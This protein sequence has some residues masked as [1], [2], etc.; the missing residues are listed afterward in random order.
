MLCPAVSLPYNQFWETILSL[1]GKPLSRV[2]TD[3]LHGPVKLPCATD[4]LDLLYGFLLVH[5]V[6]QSVHFQLFCT[7]GSRQTRPYLASKRYHFPVNS[8]SLTPLRFGSANVA[9]RTSV[10]LPSQHTYSLRANVV[11]LHRANIGIRLRA[12]VGF[13]HRADVSFVRRLNIGPRAANL[14]GKHRHPLAGRCS[15][16]H[17]ANIGIRLR[18]NV[19]F[20]RRL[21]IGPRAAHKR[22]PIGSRL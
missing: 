5:L 20:V 15:F 22:L 12:D 10:L 13:V 4:L 21:N 1:W 17:R 16:F 6:L 8:R 9:S 18:A 2:F 19:S 3:A 7:I 14:S 11:F